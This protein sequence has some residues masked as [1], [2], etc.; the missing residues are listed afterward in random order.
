ML[1]NFPKTTQLEIRELGF[2]SGHPCGPAFRALLHSDNAED[3]D[4]RKGFGH[5]WNEV[6]QTQ[7]LRPGHTIWA[8]E[9]EY[10]TGRPET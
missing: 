6:P 10:W 4:V 7:M 9:K 2:G 1:I 5:K 3:A 8:G